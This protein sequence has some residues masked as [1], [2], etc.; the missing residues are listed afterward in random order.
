ML[1]ASDGDEFELSEEASPE[2]RAEFTS[3]NA[4]CLPE[5]PGF[6]E[7]SLSKPD[8]ESDAANEPS[9]SSPFMRR[10]RARGE[11]VQLTESEIA[12]A[13]ALCS[14]RSSTRGKNKTYHCDMCSRVFSSN[15]GARYHMSH[16]V[17]R[18]PLGVKRN[19]AATTTTTAETIW[20]LPSSPC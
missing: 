20:L 10:K 13:E 11:T 1:P 8:Q 2:P 19:L 7:P 14:L 16:N 3:P 17:C 5:P 9:S 12:A 15:Y 6:S 4:I 18:K